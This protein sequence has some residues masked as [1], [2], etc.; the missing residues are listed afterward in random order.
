MDW[1]RYDSIG[2][3]W[4]RNGL[5][6]D[7]IVIGALLSAESQLAP[8]FL[9]LVRVSDVRPNVKNHEMARASPDSRL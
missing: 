9:A 4:I 7:W 1:I 8:R 3:D 2:L 6:M 5:E